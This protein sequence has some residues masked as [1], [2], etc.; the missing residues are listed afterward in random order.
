MKEALKSQSQWAESGLQYNGKGNITLRMD[1]K[2][3]PS[4]AHTFSSV[5]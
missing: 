4:M 1:C 3:G 5:H 2:A